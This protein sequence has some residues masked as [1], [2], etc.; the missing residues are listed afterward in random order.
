MNL[1]VVLLSS[2]VCPGI[3]YSTLSSSAKCQLF[4]ITSRLGVEE[5]WGRIRIILCAAM[6]LVS[7]LGQKS[8]KLLKYT[9][10]TKHVCLQISQAVFRQPG[11]HVYDNTDFIFVKA[12][13]LPQS[14]HG[15]IKLNNRNTFRTCGLYRH[16][17]VPK[18]AHYTSNH[19]YILCK[20]LNSI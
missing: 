20:F 2:F 10:D 3:E 15:N 12:S 6:Q 11:K 18:V 14:R 8:S 7:P 17:L 4:E 9:S 1:A 19:I 13:Q 5:N 16:I